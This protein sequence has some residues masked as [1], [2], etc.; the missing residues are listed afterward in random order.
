MKIRYSKKL[1]LFI[2]DKVS[3]GYTVADICERMF[4][5]QVPHSKSVYRWQKENQEFKDMMTDAY[6]LFFERKL[7]ELEYISKA[8]LADLYPDIKDQRERFEAR[9]TRL[10]TLK[11]EL[12]KLAPVLTNRF[13]S[14]QRVEI[15]HS[16]NMPSI[17]IVSYALPKSNDHSIIDIHPDA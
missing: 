8:S 16:G 7:E 6:V 14:K 15:E 4:K 3:E 9:R 17:Q 1:A 2:A 13:N 10:D 5:G 11:F 12:G